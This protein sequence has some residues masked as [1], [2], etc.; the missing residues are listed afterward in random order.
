MIST[1]DK[2]SA[3]TQVNTFVRLGNG[4]SENSGQKYDPVNIDPFV[5]TL[6]L[7]ANEYMVAVN[8]DGTMSV[9]HKH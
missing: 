6:S 8:E 1:W 5:V 4:F 9:T 3:H 2:A 7:A